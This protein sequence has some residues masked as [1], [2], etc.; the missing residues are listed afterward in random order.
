MVP[1]GRP[2]GA[3]AR[4]F[5]V[6]AARRPGQRL[7]LVIAL[8]S[9]AAAGHYSSEDLFYLYALLPLAVAFVAEQLRVLSAQAMLDQRGLEGAAEV[10]TLPESEQQLRRHRG[11]CGASSA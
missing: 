1:R 8:G 10:G 6:G 3:W 11:A 9:L 5:W 7:A 4:A 2:G